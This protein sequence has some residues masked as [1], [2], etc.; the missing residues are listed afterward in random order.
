MQQQQQQHG[1][2]AV[3]VV[4]HAPAEEEVEPCLS[5]W[6]DEDVAPIDNTARLRGVSLTSAALQLLAALPGAPPAKP[7]PLSSPSPESCS[8]LPVCSQSDYTRRLTAAIRAIH[9]VSPDT[10]R[11]LA[12]SLSSP[13]P[14]CVERPVPPSIVLDLDWW[15]KATNLPLPPSNTSTANDE[16]NEKNENNESNENKESNN[17]NDSIYSVAHYEQVISFLVATALAP[18]RLGKRFLLETTIID[19]PQPPIPIVLSP[20][21]KSD[22][23]VAVDT[24]PQAEAVA[25]AAERVKAESRGAS[26]NVSQSAGL[27][28]NSETSDGKTRAYSLSFSVAGYAE[29][30]SVDV[31]TLIRNA[32]G[33]KPPPAF[34][35]GG[36]SGGNNG[37]NTGG[38]TRTYTSAAAAA[39]TFDPTQM[40]RNVRTTSPLRNPVSNNV[41]TAAIADQKKLFTVLPSM[42]LLFFNRPVTQTSEGTPCFHRTSIE[43]PIDIDIGFAA[44]PEALAAAAAAAQRR[45]RGSS[46][47][48]KGGGSNGGGATGT[49][50]RLHGFVTQTEGRFIVYMRVKE[51]R[52]FWKVGDDGSV[53][54]DE[55]DLGVRVNSKGVVAALYRSGD[56][57]HGGHQNT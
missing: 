40:T 56:A 7:A 45:N 27:D 49:F 33:I 22:V 47:K 48:K 31:I 43:V 2:N 9:R 14:Y 32:F 11:P 41:N 39:A 1:G 26:L 35:F 25:E 34:F 12:H 50:Y 16:N 24:V 29:H 44:S 18:S 8:E 6:P 13:S 5:Y 4:V 21:E 30:E 54:E 42:L 23:L 36:F 53:A 46:S 37:S 10:G 19:A 38:R 52:G 20:A 15:R 3:T 28:C 57:G 51:S 17:N 55:V